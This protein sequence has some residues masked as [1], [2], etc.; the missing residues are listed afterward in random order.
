MPARKVTVVPEA[1]PAVPSSESIARSAEA[2]TL[3]AIPVVTLLL[4]SEESLSGVDEV[5]VAVLVIVPEGAPGDVF[6]DSVKV[7]SA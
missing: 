7:V 5:M 1:T 2:V 4:L 6:T 3:P